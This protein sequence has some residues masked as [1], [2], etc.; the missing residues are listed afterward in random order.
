MKEFIKKLSVY[1]KIVI[2]I[3]GVTVILNLIAFSSSFCDAYTDTVYGVI[4]DVEGRVTDL[5]PFILGE[6]IMYL[7][8]LSVL[9][10]VIVSLLMLFV[11]K[12]GFRT[13]AIRFDKGFLLYVVIML[14]VYTLN[15]SIPYRGKLLGG[16]AEL[17][18]PCDEEHLRELREYLLGRLNLE[19]T[20]VPRNEAGEVIWPD[21]ETVRNE[22]SVSM[23]ALSDMYPRLKGYYPRLKKAMCSEVLEYMSIG[24]FTYPYTMEQTCNAFLDRFYYP[25]LFAHE[26]AHH[27]GYYKE[28]EA[29]FLSFLA[30][31]YSDDATLRYSGYMVAYSYVD[32]AYRTFYNDLSDEL[33]DRY[34]ENMPTETVRHDRAYALKIAAEEFE[35]SARI[36][37]V[38]Q[39]TAEKTAQAGWKTQSNVIATNSYDAVVLLI[40]EYYN[41]P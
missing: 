32:R 39:K 2:G 26:A 23:R 37:R 3:F 20:L 29:N 33:K 16:K 4:A 14:L 36:F 9:A 13:F 22:I 17:T 12:K 27:Q 41:H 15:W 8:A 19:A 31:I 28:N 10:V 34:A 30:C 11:K 5:F 25:S 24:G 35:N 38:F 21:D 1:W 40:L 6:I 7:S 18:T